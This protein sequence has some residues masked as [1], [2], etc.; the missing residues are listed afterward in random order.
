MKR[1]RKDGKNIWKNCTKKDLNEPDNH[2]GVVS[3]PEPDILED[4]VN[5]P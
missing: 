4:E 2:D 5:G 3:H 1:S